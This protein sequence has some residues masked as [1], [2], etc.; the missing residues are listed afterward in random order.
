[1]CLKWAR[2]FQVSANPST[3][4]GLAHHTRQAT[5]THYDD[6]TGVPWG[7]GLYMSRRHEAN[8]T[9]ADSKRHLGFRC[10]A[11]NKLLTLQPALNP[12]TSSPL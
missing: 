1:M 9:Q 8:A 6:L 5:G 11:S 12:L 7:K 4:F 10:A 2:A 3:N